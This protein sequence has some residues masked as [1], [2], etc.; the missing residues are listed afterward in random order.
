MQE[1]IRKA[2]ADQAR[3]CHRQMKQPEPVLIDPEVVEVRD[4]S[5]CLALLGE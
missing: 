2:Q 3:D 1:A 5:G 4:A